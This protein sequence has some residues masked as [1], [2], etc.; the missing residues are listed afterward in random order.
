MRQLVEAVASFVAS[1]G[2]EAAVGKRR[3]AGETPHDVFSSTLIVSSGLV[4]DG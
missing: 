3:R 4:G 2:A 1:G